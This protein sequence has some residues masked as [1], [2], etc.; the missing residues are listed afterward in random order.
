MVKCSNGNDARQVLLY[1][2]AGHCRGRY[3]LTSLGN[4]LGRISVSGLAKARQ[5]MSARLTVDDGLR[6]RVDRIRKKLR[7]TEDSS[8]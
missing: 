4:R 7:S 1:L 6:V 8:S 3:T 2:A 5:L